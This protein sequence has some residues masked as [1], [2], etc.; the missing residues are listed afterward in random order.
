MEVAPFDV[1]QSRE[2]QLRCKAILA[3]LFGHSDFNCIHLN[4]RDASIIFVIVLWKQR[5]ENG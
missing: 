4:K 3:M 5:D 1:T 2:L